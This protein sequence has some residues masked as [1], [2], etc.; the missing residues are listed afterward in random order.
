MIII[1]DLSGTI[2]AYIF[3]NENN[4]LI[5]DNEIYLHGNNNLLIYNI[6]YEK[7]NY[8][9]KLVYENRILLINEKIQLD[10]SSNELNIN[11][12]HLPTNYL[13]V[14]DE[15]NKE[16]IKI[17]V[18]RI[19]NDNVKYKKI[20]DLLNDL[21]IYMNDEYCILSN[22]ELYIYSYINTDNSINFNFSN[23]NLKHLLYDLDFTILDINYTIN[24]IKLLSPI[25]FDGTNNTNPNNVVNS[26]L[27]SKC[28]KKK[29]KFDGLITNYNIEINN[30]N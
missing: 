8:N 13:T 16:I 18:T 7:F 9:F 24:V 23:T 6:L 11:I 17:N 10:N 22:P 26:Y 3:L 25:Y 29:Y 20:I 1:R 2:C 21:K 30:S 27:I 15:N 12:I 19:L 28:T 4:K 14:Y 5:I